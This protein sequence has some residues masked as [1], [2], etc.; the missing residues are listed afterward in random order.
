MAGSVSGQDFTRGLE[1]RANA[2]LQ[3]NIMVNSPAIK[4][5]VEGALKD[6]EPGKIA[7]FIEESAG[8]PLRAK[9]AG[10]DKIPSGEPLLSAERMHDFTRAKLRVMAM[11]MGLTPENTVK[12]AEAVVNTGKTAITSLSQED[13]AYLQNRAEC[14]VVSP[15]CPSPA[16]DQRQR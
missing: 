9:L 13:K 5:L 2:A 8:D 6:V 15:N 14:T 4:I 16:P 11:D 3:N 7:D 10:L 1:D 12:F